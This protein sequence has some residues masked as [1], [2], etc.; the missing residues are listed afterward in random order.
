MA[1]RRT[2]MLYKVKFEARTFQTL[3]TPLRT[4]PFVVFH[5]LEWTTADK[6]RDSLLVA[7]V[8]VLYYKYRALTDTMR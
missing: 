7:P 5:A 2:Q 1:C 6:H 4:C 8:N 3:R